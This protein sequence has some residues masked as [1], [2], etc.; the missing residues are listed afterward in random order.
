MVCMAL[1]V[2]LPYYIVHVYTYGCIELVQILQNRIK[3][4]PRSGMSQNSQKWLSKKAP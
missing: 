1:L 2:W 3:A 4:I